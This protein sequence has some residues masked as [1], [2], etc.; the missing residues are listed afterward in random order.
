[1]FAR[2]PFAV[3]LL[4]VL[5][6]TVTDRITGQPLPGVTVTAG[7]VH[8]TTHADGSYR[9]DGLKPGRVTVTVTSDDVPPQAFPVTVGPATTRANLRACSRTLDYNCGAPQ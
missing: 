2:S 9:L 5:V 1:M 8:A 6:G 3:L 4:A 7:P